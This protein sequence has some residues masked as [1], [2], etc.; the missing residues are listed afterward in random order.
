MLRLAFVVVSF[1]A[2]VGCNQNNPASCAIEGNAGKGGCPDAPPIDQSCMGPADCMSTPSTPVCAMG[3]SPRVCVTCTDQD[4]GACAATTRLCKS[5]QCASCTLDSEC[6]TGGLCLPDGAC[7]TAANIIHAAS[8]GGKDVP[9][10]GI[11]SGPGACKLERALTEVTDTKNVIKLD[12]NGTYTPGVTNFVV[13]ANV[14]IDARGSAPGGAVLHKKGDGPLLSISANKTAT[15]FGGT[16]E[17]AHGPTGDGIL[18][19]SNA[20]LTIDGTT[21]QTSEQSA[22]NALPGC[23]LTVTHANI[24]TNSQK[25]GPF[26]ASILAGGASVTLSRTLFLQNK[27]GGINVTSGTFVIVGNAFSNSGDPASSIGGV[28]INTTADPMNRIEFNTIES[29][30]TMTGKVPG[31]D[32]TSGTGAIARNNIIWGNNNTA[33]VPPPPTVLQIGGTCKHAYS[34]IGMMDLGGPNDNGSNTNLGVDPMFTMPALDLHLKA[35]SMMIMRAD[36]NAKLDGVA[37]ID[38]DG[39][40]RV[41]PADIGAVQRPRP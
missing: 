27:G 18:C 9:G 36:P 23:N 32:C 12:D 7:A 33:T 26:V 38:I 39:T 37:A 17:G 30:R 8:T 3:D 29:N 28:L 16:I 31:V 19:G 11:P 2:F 14:I 13:T 5:N 21:I 25:G 41:A 4:L 35:G 22:I 34:D 15:I 10:C 1:V 6:G 24:N 20:K 40:P